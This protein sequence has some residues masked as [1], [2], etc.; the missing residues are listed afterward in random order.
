[1]WRRSQAGLAF[2]GIRDTKHRDA[3]A[4][5]NATFGPATEAQAILEERGIT[6]ETLAARGHPGPTIAKLAEDNDVDLVVVGT[7][8]LGAIQR[9]LGQSVSQAVSR[10]VPCDLLI[11]Q[12]GTEAA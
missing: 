8:E 9:L 2:P 1:L 4:R 3:E 7:R 11:V 6:A 12:A 10:R 5:K